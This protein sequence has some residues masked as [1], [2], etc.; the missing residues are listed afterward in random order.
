M[1]WFLDKV[2]MKLSLHFLILWI[3]NY[4]RC[5]NSQKVFIHTWIFSDISDSFRNIAVL[6]LTIL[7]GVEWWEMVFVLEVHDYKSAMLIFLFV[8]AYMWR[9]CVCV[10]ACECTYLTCQ[11]QTLCMF[12]TCQEW[13]S[14]QQ[15]TH[16]MSTLDF[17]FS[18]GLVILKNPG[19]APKIMG[20]AWVCSRYWNYFSNHLHE[21]KSALDQNL[22][23][24]SPHF[25]R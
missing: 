4:A 7:E 9:V 2:H 19:I 8:R 5:T 21:W 16:S 3:R 11:E 10:H 23:H 18:F 20:V 14:D 24:S 6:T 25:T 17:G 15:W 22:I 12:C 1:E 13:T